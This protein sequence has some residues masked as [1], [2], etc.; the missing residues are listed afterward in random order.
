MVEFAYNNSVHSSSA[1]TPFY[2]CY[3]RHPISPVNL[4]SRW[5]LGMRLQTHFSDSWRRMWLRH[6]R[7][8][9]GRR[10]GKRNMQI[11][12]EGTWNFR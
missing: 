4:V 10:I 9:D 1:Y 6:Y 12:G 7:I 5:N 8:Y 11:E 2:L 3:G